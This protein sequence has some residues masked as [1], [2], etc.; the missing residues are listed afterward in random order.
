[1]YGG[2]VYSGRAHWSITH[3]WVQWIG[4]MY[5]GMHQEFVW[6]RGEYPGSLGADRRRVAYQNSAAPTSSP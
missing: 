1:M 4:Q 3:L 5:A 6:Q 2:S